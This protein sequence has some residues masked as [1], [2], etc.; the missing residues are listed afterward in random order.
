MPQAGRHSYRTKSRQFSAMNGSVEALDKPVLR[1][2]TWR[3]IVLFVAGF[4]AHDRKEFDV[5]SAPRGKSQLSPT[6][7]AKQ[8]IAVASRRQLSTRLTESSLMTLRVSGLITLRRPPSAGLCGRPMSISAVSR[9]P[10]NRCAPEAHAIDTALRPA[11]YVRFSTDDQ[12]I[13]QI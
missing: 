6:I 13:G 3:D 1:R 10:G 11:R 2:L 5:S 4:A 12:K 7:N 9:A 8:A